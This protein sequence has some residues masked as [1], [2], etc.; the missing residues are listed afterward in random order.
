M[1]AGPNPP[2]SETAAPAARAGPGPRTNGVS[3]SL[4]CEAGAVQ[5]ENS[6][7]SMASIPSGKPLTG[8]PDARNLPVR[9][10]GRGSGQPLSLPLFYSRTIF[11]QLFVFQRRD[12]ELGQT[13]LLANKPAPITFE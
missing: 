2:H 10:G 12:G 6:P 9:F 13:R 5:L 3:D 7:S 4:V 11:N 8:E 1:D